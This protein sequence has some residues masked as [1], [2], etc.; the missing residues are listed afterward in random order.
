MLRRQ[1]SRDTSQEV[2]IVCTKVPP[3]HNNGRSL[4]EHF[5][6]FGKVKKVFPNPSKARAVI[7]FETHVSFIAGKFFL[8][9]YLLYTKIILDLVSKKNMSTGDTRLVFQVKNLLMTVLVQICKN[10]G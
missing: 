6:K 9:F 1:L 7:H 4:R 5:N 8:Y 3:K 10:I 2:A